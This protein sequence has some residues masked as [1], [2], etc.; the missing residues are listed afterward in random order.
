MKPHGP[1]LDVIMF[2][3]SDHFIGS[4]VSSLT[5]FATRA[6]HIRGDPTSFWGL[7]SDDKHNEL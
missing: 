2:E 1:Q 4:C 3:L 7:I 6:R 5:A